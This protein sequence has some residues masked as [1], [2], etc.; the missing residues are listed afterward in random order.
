MEDNIYQ[1]VFEEGSIF[2]LLFRDL[3]IEDLCLNTNI[4][5]F[6]QSIKTT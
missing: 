3:K 4:P 6:W 2:N 1:S 5:A